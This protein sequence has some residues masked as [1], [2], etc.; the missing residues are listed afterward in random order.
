MHQ[1][2]VKEKGSDLKNAGRALIL[3]H[4]RGATAEN[5]L[6]LADYFTDGSWY[7]VAPQATDFRWYPYSFLMPVSRNEPWLSSA[8]DY[9]KKMID[10]ISLY[11]PAENIYLMGFSQGACLSVEIAARFATK[12]GG[13]AAFTGGLIGETVDSGSYRGDFMG[14]KIYISNG[15][16]DPH[17]PLKRSEE[18]LKQLRSM[19]ADARL[20]IF[21]GR[22]H[23]IIPEEIEKAK[24]FLLS[25]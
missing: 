14:T 6:P 18:T 10:N 24:D 16:D 5:I 1:Y 4:G 20:D 17:I 8:V 3:L 2:E 19:G 21:P 9:V 15:D 12:Y 7:V 13:I 22:D 25:R 11:I 23:T